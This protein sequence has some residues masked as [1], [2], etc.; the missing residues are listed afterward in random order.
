MS[1]ASAFPGDSGIRHPTVGQVDTARCVI[2]AAARD[3]QF[4]L[5]GRGFTAVSAA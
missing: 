5:R 1:K 2:G 4:T 3:P